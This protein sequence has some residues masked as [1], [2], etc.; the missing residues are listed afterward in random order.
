M[1]KLSISSQEV[2]PWLVRLT[3]FKSARLV[4][5]TYKYVSPTWERTSPVATAE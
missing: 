2:N 1:K 4:G 5:E 3:S